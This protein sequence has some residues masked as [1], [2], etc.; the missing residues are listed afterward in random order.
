MNDI[1][2]LAHIL[3]R[4]LNSLLKL[5]L[6]FYKPI[7]GYGSSPSFPAFE[8]TQ[9]KIILPQNL[10]LKLISSIEKY[11]DRSKVCLFDNN[12]WIL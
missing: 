6:T 11:C 2:I 9:H 1:T 4:T 12:I 10:I 8:N 5:H 3:L 7:Y